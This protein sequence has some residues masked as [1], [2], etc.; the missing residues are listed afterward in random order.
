MTRL[1]F[2]LVLLFNLNLSYSQS[3]K[4]LFD[5]EFE[6]VTLNGVLNLPN[7]SIP[8]G[9]VLI[10]HG[11]GA[12]NAVAQEWHQDVRATLV[13]A[14]YATYMWDKMGCGNS[15]GTFN[16]NQPVQNSA[17]E[18]IAAINTLKE[19]Q[20]PGA[21]TIGLWGISRAGWINPLVINEYKDIAFWISASGV[22]D[23]ENFN[24]L[25]AQNMRIE[26]MPEDSIQLM[27]DEMV[28]STRI[29]HAGGDYKTCMAAIP[30]LKKNEFWLR[31]TNG[32]ISEESYYANQ[33][34]FMEETLDEATGLQVYIPDFD[35][36]LSKINCPVLA[37]FGEQDK[38]VDWTKTKA[39]YERTIDSTKLNVYQFSACNHNLF[40]CETGG[41]YE[42]QDNNLPW[43]RCEGVLE[44]MKIWL[45]ERF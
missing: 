6:E 36:T 23:K 45:K 44:T 19:E 35:A 28:E 33:K 21:E 22:D 32:G 20:I 3:E 10:V 39:L 15:G 41:F 30:N 38:N 12:T 11:S 27:L 8:K 43:V 7:G 9:I 24:Y 2:F 13:Q 1:T 18:V 14:G 31:F 16:Y 29:S 42:F 37:L 25:W 34:G 26:G 17:A 5:F 40:Q 4:R